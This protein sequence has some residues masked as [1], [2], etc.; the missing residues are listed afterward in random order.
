LTQVTAKEQIA[1]FS[2]GLAPIPRVHMPHSILIVAALAACADA[3][4]LRRHRQYRQLTDIDVVAEIMSGEKT[5]LEQLVFAN[6]M[7]L[8]EVAPNASHKDA[9][10]AS[11]LVMA[12]ATEHNVKAVVLNRTKLQA[13]NASHKDA[14]NA[15]HLVTANATEHNVKAHVLNRTKLQKEKANLDTLLSHLKGNVISIN[16]VEAE[17]KDEEQEQIVK[18]KERL[19]EEYKQLNGTNLTTFRR[20]LLTN[21]THMAESELKYWTRQRDLQHHMF[22]SS[23]KMTHGLMNKVKAVMEAYKE[24]LAKGHVSKATLKDMHAVAA[25]LPRALLQVDDGE[26]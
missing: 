23:L 13:P 26:E 1:W 20:S 4:L 5:I 10:N 11:H 6:Q 22:H 7:L 18:V 25:K 16:K 3:V 2:G 12:N 21:R 14:P 19:A 8:E 24:A 17:G 9:P 15:S